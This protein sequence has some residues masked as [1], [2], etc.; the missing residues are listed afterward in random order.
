VSRVEALETDTSKADVSTEDWWAAPA[1]TGAPPETPLKVASQF[2]DDESTL[3]WWGAETD[4]S[5][6]A[7]PET[8]ATAED[9]WGTEATESSPPVQM[10]AE[11][12]SAPQTIKPE[13]DSEADV[14]DWWAGGETESLPVRE[15][16]TPKVE[17]AEKKPEEEVDWWAAEPSE[18][19]TKKAT[20]TSFENKDEG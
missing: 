15:M 5:H 1:E 17:V 4:K 6:Q 3:D 18:S 9:E 2:E 7:K 20:G 13:T 19:E 12:V 14:P 8:G 11:P 16:T 10:K